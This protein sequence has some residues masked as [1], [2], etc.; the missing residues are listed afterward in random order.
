MRSGSGIG[1][2]LVRGAPGSGARRAARHPR[3]ARPRSVGSRPPHGRSA[4][5]RRVRGARRYACHADRR[6]DAGARPGDARAAR[7][8]PRRASGSSRGD[9]DGPRLPALA[10]LGVVAGGRRLADRRRGAPRARGSRGRRLRPGEL[11]G[12]PVRARGLAGALARRLRGGAARV[13]P[14]GVGGRA[15][16]GADRGADPHLARRVPEREPG[17]R[18]R[19]GRRRGLRPSAPGTGSTTASAPGRRTPRSRA[20]GAGGA[21]LLLGAPLHTIS[22]LHHAEAVARAPKR[23]TTYRLPVLR[24]G[25]RRWVAIRELDVWCGA[26]PYER[27]VSD[28]VE[29]LGA[30]AADARPPASAAAIVGEATAH[31]FPAGGADGAFAAAVA[32]GAVRRRLGCG[33]CDARPRAECRRRE[34]RALREPGQEAAAATITSRSQPESRRDRRFGPIATERRKLR[35]EPRQLDVLDPPAAS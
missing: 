16:R 5:A 9:R 34:L 30:I 18:A 14:G 7:R 8:R 33:W 28:G 27:V 35:L 26:F 31:L 20:P 2:L 23:W 15:V 32:R 12:R 3:S 21:V 19:R 10:R 4:V 13:R 11:G 6:R 25:A 22:L 17:H 1:L 29:P 24:S